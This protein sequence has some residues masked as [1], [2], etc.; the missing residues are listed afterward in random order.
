MSRFESFSGK[1]WR[2]GANC[3]TGQIIPGKYVPV[4]DPH[5]LAKHLFEDVRPDLLGQLTPGDIVVAGPNFGCGSSR[6]HAPKALKYA[7]VSAVVA[8]SFARIFFRNALNIGLLAIPAFGVSSE[9]EEGHSL[10]VKVREGRVI[11]REKGKEFSFV[12]YD[13]FILE[14]IENGGIIKHTLKMLQGDLEK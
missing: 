1:V 2:F 8:D 13:D 10:T 5:E 14:M 9:V 7:G 4:T 3:D 11:Y 6:E 12:P